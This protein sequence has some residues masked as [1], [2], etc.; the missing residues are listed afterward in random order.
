[1]LE[2]SATVLLRLYRY[3]ISCE[4][5]MYTSETQVGMKYVSYKRAS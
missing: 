5:Y 1:M 2:V 3:G 4:C